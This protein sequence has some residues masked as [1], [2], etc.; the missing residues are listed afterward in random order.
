LGKK[1][2]EKNTYFL[3][4]DKH[5]KIVR[6]ISRNII[7]SIQMMEGFNYDCRE[8]KQSVLSDFRRGVNGIPFLL[9]S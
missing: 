5:D 6:K 9:V 4:N 7:I 2:K 8:N 3:R 1:A